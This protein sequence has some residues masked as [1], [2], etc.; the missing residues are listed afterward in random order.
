MTFYRFCNK[1]PN[2]KFEK[3]PDFAK[4][5]LISEHDNPIVYD[6]TKKHYV[7]QSLIKDNPKKWNT[8]QKLTH[9]NMTVLKQNKKRAI[10]NGH[11]QVQT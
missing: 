10:L 6:L 9:T 11:Q 4:W 7:C 1:T 2:N 8:N 5:V 3:L